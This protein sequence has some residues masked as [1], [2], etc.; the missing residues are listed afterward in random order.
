MSPDASK[1]NAA[2]EL[3]RAAEVDFQNEMR[4]KAFITY[5]A[6]TGML[7]F[8]AARYA[9]KEK[10]NPGDPVVTRC[11]ELLVA[12][13]V[14]AMGTPAPPGGAVGWLN[15]HRAVI[16]AAFAIATVFLAFLVLKKF[17]ALNAAVSAIR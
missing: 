1:V 14:A 2:L 16:I 5:C 6:Q 12:Q 4:H 17:L 3:W 15:R 9:E 13:A 7:P 8:A 10:A 11:R